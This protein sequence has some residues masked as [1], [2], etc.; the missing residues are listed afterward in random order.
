MNADIEYS[1]IAY[2]IDANDVIVYVDEHWGPFTRSNGAPELT[3][4][5]VVGKPS[6][7]SSPMLASDTCMTC[8]M[9]R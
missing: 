1:Q 8:C 3:A 6:I 5:C 7:V 2:G 4:E 9:L